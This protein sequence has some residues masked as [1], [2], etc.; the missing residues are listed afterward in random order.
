MKLPHLLHQ[1]TDEHNSPLM[2][3]RGTSV[4]SSTHQQLSQR[5]PSPAPAPAPPTTEELHTT[6]DRQCS[7]HRCPICS[8]S[9]KTITILRKHKLTV[10]IGTRCRWGDCNEQFGNET[11]LFKHIRTHQR[12]GAVGD[13]SDQFL[14]HWPDCSREFRD[15]AELSRHL[16][17]HNSTA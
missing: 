2:L 13:A 1:H 7:L 12:Y 10:H 6:A 8:K 11:Q 15:D 3:S 16:K 14:C 17:I 5:S 9:F 4:I